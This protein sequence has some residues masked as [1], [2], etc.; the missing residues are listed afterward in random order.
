MSV[1]LC[2]P[3]SLGDG[4]GCFSSE[5]EQLYHVFSV[6]YLLASIV[7]LMQ[8]GKIIYYSLPGTTLF[9]SFPFFFISFSPTHHHSHHPIT[10]ATTTLTIPPFL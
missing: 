10:T 1:C 8:V 4:S 7:A 6:L 5:V 3:V 2:L 9:F